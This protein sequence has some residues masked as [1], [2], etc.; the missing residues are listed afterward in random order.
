LEEIKLNKLMP[1]SCFSSKY[2]INLLDKTKP[3]PLYKRVYS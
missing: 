1:G 2:M 3:N